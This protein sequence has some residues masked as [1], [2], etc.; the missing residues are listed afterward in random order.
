KRQLQGRTILVREDRLIDAAGTLAGANLSMAHA[1]A[2]VV[3]L[4]GATHE[5][6]IAMASETPARFLGLSGELGRIAPGLRADLIAL[7]ADG[8]VA[9]SWIAG[10]PYVN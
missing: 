9:Q 10:E 3:A 1:V 8:A 5:A 6:A 2:N 4:L 7:T